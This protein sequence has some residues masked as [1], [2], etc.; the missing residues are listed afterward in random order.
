MPFLKIVGLLISKVFY[1][2]L[3]SYYVDQQCNF[4][5]LYVKELHN[6]FIGNIW[7]IQLKIAINIV[8]HR[9]TDQERVIHSISDNVEIMIKD[10]PDKV[11]EN[12]FQ[13]LLSRYQ[14][15]L[16]TSM[17]GRDLIFDCVNLL[18]YECH[19]ISFKRG[20]SSIDYPDWIKNKKETINPINKKDN[21]CFQYFVTVAL[22]HEEIGKHSERIIK[23]K[24]FIHKYNWEGINCPSE[25]DDW[26][27]VENYN[28]TIAL[29]VLYAK[30]QKID[31][32]YVS[33][34]NS[35]R[36]KTSYYFN[37]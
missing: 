36:E 6:N 5:W 14:T 13:S 37:D 19:K 3:K 7:K 25:K 1:Y 11:T 22:D 28:L 26:K 31:H 35:N 30:K 17:K 34:Q 12:F 24:T 32:V 16:E 20:G 23:N 9:E 33:K 15:G 10:K 27:K 21:K 2:C 4:F 29:N 8:S 18:Y